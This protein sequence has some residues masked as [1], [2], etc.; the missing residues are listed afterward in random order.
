MS[1]EE[2][3][4]PSPAAPNYDY[5]DLLSPEELMQVD[6]NSTSFPLFFSQNKGHCSIIF[7]IRMLYK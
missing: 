5:L 4:T 7:L 1:L 6:F 3:T 2:P